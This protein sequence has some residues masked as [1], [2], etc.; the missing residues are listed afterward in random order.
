V[1]AVSAVSAADMMTFLSA[2]QQAVKAEVEERSTGEETEASEDFCCILCGFKESSV[3]K[4][5]DHINMHFIGQ[6]K[7]R[8]SEN[9]GVSEEEVGHN[10][11]KES[12]VKKVKLETQAG[13]TESSLEMESETDPLALEDPGSAKAGIPV[14]GSAK[15][16][17]P[18]SGSAKAGIPVSGSAKAGITVSGSAKTGNGVCSKAGTVS[19]A[20]VSVGSSKG[21][22][23][24]NCDISFLNPSTFNAHVQ[25]YCK[26]KE[27]SN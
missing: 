15:A 7:K 14:S 2:Q 4:L 11:V 20:P 13:D 17:I 6:V 1:S 5:K 22:T 27:G 8:K 12:A 10:K 3:D 18:V 19:S 16:G 23:C 25:F 24:T 21:L 9:D 26:N